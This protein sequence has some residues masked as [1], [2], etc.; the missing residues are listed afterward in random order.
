MGSFLD[1]V[2]NNW[3]GIVNLLTQIV[4][5][6]AIVAAWTPNTV[7]NRIA[8]LFMDGINFLGANVNRAANR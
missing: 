8:Q 4:G 6:F 7:D 5:A 2:S 3:V 1:L